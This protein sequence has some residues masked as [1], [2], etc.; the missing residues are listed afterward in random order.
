MQLNEIIPWGRS[1]DEYGLMFGL[2]ERDL[3]GRI[4][5]CGDG[6]ASFNSEA[7]SKGFSVTSCDPI[8]AFSTEQI[9]QRVE[10][11]YENVISQVRLNQ[12]GFMWDYFQDPD[13]LG[14]ARL[15]AMRAFLSD[16]EK[17]KSEDRY[18]TASL[19]NLPFSDGQFDLA[20]CS[21][22]LFL[23]SDRLSLEFHLASIEELLRV[24]AEVRIF[25]LLTLERRTSPHVEPLL[26][27][28]AERGWRTEILSVNY[29]F[30]RGGRQMLRVRKDDH[31]PPKAAGPSGLTG[32]RISVMPRTVIHAKRRTQ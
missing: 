28:L 31:P 22:L 12:E 15:T 2:S 1:F 27:Y 21:H 25:P 8:Y 11:C 3:A 5:G 23:Y 14:Q 30:Q 7:A 10:D 17:G 24:A 20:L 6:P 26:T 18:V 4:L 19:P 9:R 29:E 32:D 13:H 16:F